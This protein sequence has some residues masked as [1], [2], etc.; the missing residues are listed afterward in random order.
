MLANDDIREELKYIEEVRQKTKSEDT[1]ASL[2]A[3]S[4]II[5]LLHNI[6]TNIVT[7][8]KH[9]NIGL[10]KPKERVEDEK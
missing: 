4:L 8:M 7:T 3:L 10:I 2:K 9:Q 6:R 5:Q 1:K